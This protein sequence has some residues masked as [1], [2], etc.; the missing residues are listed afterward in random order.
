MKLIKPILTAFLVMI[1]V[2]CFSQV[3]KFKTTSISLKT[4]NES[5]RKWTKWSEPDKVEILISIDLTN[6][7][8]KIFSKV[9]QVY[10]IIK[11][12]DKETDTDGDETLSFQCV[13]QDGLKCIVRFVVL[14]SQ[15]GRR[16]LYVDYS[17]MMWMY[18]IYK[19]D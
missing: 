17:D 12:Y 3:T 8:I 4:K 13:D 6:E 19:L 15:S 1:S 7:R 14:N 10:D 2:F 18:N 16:Q 11:Y 9:D 5:T